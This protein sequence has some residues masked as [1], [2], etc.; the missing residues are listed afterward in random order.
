MCL[1][2]YTD[3]FCEGN[4]AQC[5]NHIPAH[6]DLPP[7]A[8]EAGRRGRCVMVSVPVFSPGRQLKR[9]EPPDV[10]AGIHTFSKSRLQMQKTVDQ[11]LHVK[12]ID[13]ADRSDPEKTG[14]TEQDIT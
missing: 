1:L 14:P 9:T 5:A 2:I 4:R 7:M 12:A 6:I 13:K 3:V 11:G 10:L 8:A